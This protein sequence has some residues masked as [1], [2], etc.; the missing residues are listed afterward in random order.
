[1]PVGGVLA[2]SG[3]K[4]Q[5]T[6]T[7]SAVTWTIVSWHSHGR[8]WSMAGQIG[9]PADVG[10]TGQTRLVRVLLFEQP[11]LESARFG[12]CRNYFSAQLYSAVRPDALREPPGE[13]RTT[14][15][16]VPVWRGLGITRNT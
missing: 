6:P 4:R 8:A 13:V 15:G 1:M 9:H 16:R 11:P 14:S 5:Q 2:V 7:A 10:A 12:Q 3:V